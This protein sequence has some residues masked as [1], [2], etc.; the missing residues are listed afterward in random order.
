M[1]HQSFR[2]AAPANLKGVTDNAVQREFVRV[3]GGEGGTLVDLKATACG[4]TKAPWTAGGIVFHGGKRWRIVR[5]AMRGFIT[6]PA[7]G[8]RY[9]Q[10]DGFS[11]EHGCDDLYFESCYAY[12]CGDGG[13]DLKGKNY[14]IKSAHAEGCKKSYRLWSGGKI[15]RI[16]SIDPGS[17]HLHICISA[18]HKE[19]QVITIDYLKAE[20][21][22]PLLYV[23]T[24]GTIAPKII[25]KAMDMANVPTLTKIDG[26]KPEIVWP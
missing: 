21:D 1:K 4:P 12:D 26:P 24:K 20:G 23:E 7:E 10:G 8:D 2:Y 5:C 3:T 17:C 9:W 16:A 25:I 11:S 14:H 22:V 6:E 19:Q 15:G 13:F 18:S